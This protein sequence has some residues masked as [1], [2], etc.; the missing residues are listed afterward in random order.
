MTK[1]RPPTPFKQLIYDL[2]LQKFYE[3]QINSH[4]EDSSMVHENQNEEIKALVKQANAKLDKYIN[5]HHL[6]KKEPVEVSIYM[7]ILKVGDIDNVNEKFQAEAYLEACWE[8][9]DL[10]GQ[11]IFDPLIHWDPELF[12]ENAVGQLKEEI[13]YSVKKVN[14]RTR[15]CEMRIIRGIFWEKLELNEFPLGNFL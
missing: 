2:E 8:D 14:G 13:Q 4:D 5:N 12:C 9:N 10:D 11:T 7:V 6:K 15:V 1:K 3:K